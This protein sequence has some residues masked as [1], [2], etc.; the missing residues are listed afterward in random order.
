MICNKM[1]QKRESTLTKR[2]FIAVILPCPGWNLSDQS[3]WPKTWILSAAAMVDLCENED[4][5]G[6]KDFCG[7]EVNSRKILR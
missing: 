1:E 7:R 6:A 3:S 5:G 4:D 2:Q